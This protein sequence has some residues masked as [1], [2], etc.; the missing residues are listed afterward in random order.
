MDNDRNRSYL[1]QKM[2]RHEL[3]KEIGYSVILA[4]IIIGGMTIVE[5][6]NWDIV[7]HGWKYNIDFKL[8]TGWIDSI[9]CPEKSP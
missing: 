2:L 8:P 5:A 9:V 1:E 3:L 4:I 6:V 7:F